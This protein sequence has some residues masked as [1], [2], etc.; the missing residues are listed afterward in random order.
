[1]ASA[2]NQIVHD[3]VGIA[4]NRRLGPSGSTPIETIN[5]FSE[6]LTEPMTSSPGPR[7]VA[8]AI[9]AASPATL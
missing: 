3:A 5:R 2:L 6:A 7:R 9:F 8:Y 4:D 1:L